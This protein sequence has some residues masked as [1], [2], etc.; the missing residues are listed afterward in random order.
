MP[1]NPYSLP[2]AEHHTPCSRPHG[3]QP[4]LT[5]H[6]PLCGGICRK[7]RRADMVLCMFL[8]A[9]C[10]ISGQIQYVYTLPCSHGEAHRMAS[11]SSVLSHLLAGSRRVPHDWFICL[12]S[13][14]ARRIHERSRM[15]QDWFNR[16]SIFRSECANPAWSHA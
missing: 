10:R 13:R 12:L 1:R 5:N 15:M 7:L 16:K 2:N 14:F 4:N 3:G 6:Q 11:L 8:L 9:L